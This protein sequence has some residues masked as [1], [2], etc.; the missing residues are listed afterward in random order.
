VLSSLIRL[1]P[2]RLRFRTAILIARAAAP[3]LRFT[4]V[5]QMRAAMRIETIPEI[6]A[7]HVLEVLTRHGVAFDPVIRTPGLERFAAGLELGR[8]V[9]LVSPHSMLAT[10]TVRSLYDIG[11]RVIAISPAAMIVQGTS[12]AVRVIGNSPGFLL[13]ARDLLRRNEVVGAMIDRSEVTGRNTFEVDTVKG[14]IVVADALIRLAVRS[15]AAIVFMASRMA[16]GKIVIEHVTPAAEESRSAEGVTA[17]FITF[18]QDHLAGVPR[19]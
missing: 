19:Q 11:I 1:L 12:V 15:G 13:E 16:G 14:P 18:L 10:L 2:R 8:G 6:V 5:V 7:Y 4:G 17:A 9:L 3:L